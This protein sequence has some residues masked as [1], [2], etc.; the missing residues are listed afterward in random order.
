MYELLCHLNKR[1]LVFKNKFQTPHKIKKSLNQSWHTN[2]RLNTSK[3][4]VQ[5]CS[6]LWFIENVCCCDRST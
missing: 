5:K 4:M 1:T 3:T 6:Q 2:R